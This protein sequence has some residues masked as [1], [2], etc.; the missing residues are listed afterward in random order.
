MS[1]SSITYYTCTKC[2]K[3]STDRIK[4]KRQKHCKECHREYFGYPSD[5]DHD[6]YDKD[7]SSIQCAWMD[8]YIFKFKPISNA[9]NDQVKKF[10]RYLKTID[11]PEPWQREMIVSFKFNARGRYKHNK[12]LEL[13]ETCHVHVKSL[14]SH[15]KTQKHIKNSKR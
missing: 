12:T 7:E 14:S 10:I 2:G 3:N 6:Y 8:K 9:S 15:A 4:I 13:C 11:T 5:Y 1:S